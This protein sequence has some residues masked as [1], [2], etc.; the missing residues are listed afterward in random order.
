MI[1]RSDKF[2]KGQEI[3]KAQTYSMAGHIWPKSFYWIL[4]AL[5]RWFVLNY[6]YRYGAS[7]YM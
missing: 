5:F 3:Y 6:S 2:G 7:K 1:D 4:I